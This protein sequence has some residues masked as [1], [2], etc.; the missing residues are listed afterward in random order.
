MISWQEQRKEVV[1]C[2]PQGPALEC[3]SGGNLGVYQSDNSFIYGCYTSGQSGLY[4]LH[5]RVFTTEVSRLIG[6][7][8][9]SRCN[10]HHKQTLSLK[11]TGETW[12]LTNKVLPSLWCRVLPYSQLC[13]VL[14]QRQTPYYPISSGPSTSLVSKQAGQSKLYRHRPTEM[15]TPKHNL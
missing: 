1:F 7:C 6:T 4:H 8:I 12:N 14:S 15:Y 5:G 2:S 10:I 9:C 13:P 3:R 11:L